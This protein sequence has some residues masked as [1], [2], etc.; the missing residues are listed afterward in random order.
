MKLITLHSSR[1]TR[2]C[3]LANAPHVTADQGN[4]R[5]ATKDKQPSYLEGPRQIAAE[6]ENHFD[7]EQR[8]SGERG[9]SAVQGASALYGHCAAI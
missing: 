2:R 3:H 9:C 7:S 1:F 8:A 4:F 5:S 6:S